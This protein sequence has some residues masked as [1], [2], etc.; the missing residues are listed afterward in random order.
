MANE[1]KLYKH[2]EYNSRLPRWR[3]ARDLYEGDHETLVG[4]EYLVK[5]FLECKPSDPNSNLLWTSRQ[6]RTRYQ[7]LMEIL[8]SM[9]TSIFFQKDIEYTDELKAAVTEEELAN[10]DGSDTSLKSFGKL[11]LGRMLLHGKYIILADTPRFKAKNRKEEIENNIRPYLKLIDA[12]DVPD[13]QYETLIPKDFGKLKALR[14]QYRKIEQRAS[15][16]QEAQEALWS[17]VLRLN[18]K[19]YQVDRYQGQGENKL[20]EPSNWKLRSTIETSLDFIPAVVYDDEAWIDDAAQEILRHHNL[21]SFLDNVAHFQGYQKL[22]IKSDDRSSEAVKAMAEY[23]ISIIGANGDVIA[24]PATPLS[25][26]RGLV[27]EALENVMKVGLNRLHSLPSDSKEA[28]GAQAQE[29]DKMDTSNLVLSQIES[30]ENSLNQAMSYYCKLKGKDVT[31]SV[32]LS[33]EIFPTSSEK[34]SALFMTL[35]DVLRKIPEAE[36]AAVKRLLTF[37]NFNDEELKDIS[38]ELESATLGDDPALAREQDRAGRLSSILG[39]GGE[40]KV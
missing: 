9:W 29:M 16:E 7:N 5:H 17:D 35:R 8:I 3:I 14:Y 11:V 13:W 39:T 31:K 15:L 30:L 20:T 27:G 1:V 12:I 2:P 38:T 6:R 23:L 22:F 40:P 10:I 36:K 18:G 24:V 32:K 26:L 34:L 19:T 21:R 4:E 37:F 25:D 28:P 33:R